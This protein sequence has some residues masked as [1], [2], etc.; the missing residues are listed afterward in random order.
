MQTDPSSSSSA[1]VAAGSVVGLW[2][3]PVKSMMGE[4]L[5]AAEVTERGVVGDRRFA[6]V[7]PTTGKV[8]GAKEPAEVGQLLRLPGGICGA[9][10]SRVEA[11]SGPTDDARRNGR[12]E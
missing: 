3:Y 7:D 1:R 2:R 6:V 5:N 11:A 8:A 12:D 10:P 9:S 4:E